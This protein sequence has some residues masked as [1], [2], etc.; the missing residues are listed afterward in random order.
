VKRSGAR[1]PCNAI[2]RLQLP[3]GKGESADR[4]QLLQGLWPRYN[5]Y[6]GASPVVPARG[7]TEEKPPLAGDCPLRTGWRK[8]HLIRRS[9]VSR[10]DRSPQGL[11]AANARRREPRSSV[12]ETCERRKTPDGAKRRLD[13]RHA[14]AA[15]VAL[16]TRPPAPS[17][18]LAD[19]AEVC[20][21]WAKDCGD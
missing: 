19:H 21:A 12:R 8:V 14:V 7:S 2:Q 5:R 16:D 6:P 18:R 1:K 3:F 13:A 20:S 4:K 11:L 10:R 17:V 9:A 15:K